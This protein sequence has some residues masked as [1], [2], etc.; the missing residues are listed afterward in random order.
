MSPAGAGIALV[1]AA[2]AGAGI[3]FVAAAT[4]GAA[5]PAGTGARS[6]HPTTDGINSDARTTILRMERAP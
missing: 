5:A 6:L 2:T 1:A 4:A 3:A